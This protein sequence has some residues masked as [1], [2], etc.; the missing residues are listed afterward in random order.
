MSFVSALIWIA[1]IYVVYYLIVIIYDAVTARIV[2]ETTAVEEFIVQRPADNAVRVVASNHDDYKPKT[3]RE[4]A[5]VLPASDGEEISDGSRSVAEKKKLT[6]GIPMVKDVAKITLADLK[7][8]FPI[9]GQ[10]LVIDVFKES[11]ESSYQDAVSEESAFRKLLRSK[12][13]N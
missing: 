13:I 7:M 2:Q 8:N 12:S 3:P 5:V 4:V 1:V 10:Q 9:D 11:C 6:V